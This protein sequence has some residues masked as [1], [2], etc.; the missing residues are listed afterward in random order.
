MSQRHRPWLRTADVSATTTRGKTR[1]ERPR[2]GRPAVSSKLFL[3]AKEQVHDMFF[4]FRVTAGALTPQ[5]GDG[6]TLRVSTV[7]TS[8]TRRAVGIGLVS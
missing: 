3:V 4:L 1:L 5:A 2:Y 6:A 8:S 7:M